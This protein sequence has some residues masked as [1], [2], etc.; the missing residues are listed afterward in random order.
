MSRISVIPFATL[1][2]A[3]CGDKDESSGDYG[4]LS[5]RVA[6]L[7]SQVSGDTTGDGSGSTSDLDSDVASLQSLLDEVQTQLATA[8]ETIAA[9]ESDMEDVQGSL[10]AVDVSAVEALVTDL[11]DDV[12]TIEERVTSAE[13]SV[14]ELS[15]RGGVWFEEGSGT[16]TCARVDVVTDSDRPLVAMAYIDSSD[17]MST[18]V[19][20]ISSSYCTSGNTSE[21]SSTTVRLVTENV[22]GDTFTDS[23]DVTQELHVGTT[24]YHALYG[25][26]EYYYTRVGSSFRHGWTTP[27]TRVLEIP[28]AG[29]YTVEVQ[30]ES[31]ATAGTCRLI[32]IQP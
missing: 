11:E 14:L 19:C 18:S 8:N 3:G 2:F 7:E 1:L 29:S 27:V 28:S 17:S 22:G 30:V 6:V 20:G 24:N 16:G 31:T 15:D 23:T 13:D 32:V 25:A 4:E 10:E 5:E 9:L 21:T 12:S 26:Y